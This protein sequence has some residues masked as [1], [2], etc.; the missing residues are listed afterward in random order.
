MS[1]AASGQNST[2]N[3][4]ATTLE[5]GPSKSEGRDTN[6]NRLFLGDNLEVMRHLAKESPESIDLVYIDPPFATG[7]AWHYNPEPKTL[8]SSKSQGRKAIHA[9]AYDDDWGENIGDYIDWMKDR[10]QLIHKLLQPEG[11]LLLHCDHRANHHLS[12]LC[13]E[14]FGPGDRR[15]GP[16][17]AGFR[18]EIIWSYGLGGSSPRCYPKKH[19]TI[20]WYTKSE[21]WTFKPPM[22]PAT[23]AK[24]KGKLK[25]A[26]DTWQIP[27]L[28]NMARE[29]TGYPTQKP[30]ALLERIIEAHTNP[31]DLV[32]DFFC[33]SGTT[34]IAAERGK[35]RWLGCD[36]TAMSIH[37]IKK[38]L[39][40]LQNPK[41][42]QIL[43][44]NASSAGKGSLPDEKLKAR[45]LESY[46]SIPCAPEEVF[47]ARKDNT[48]IWIAPSFHPVRAEDLNQLD[49]LAAKNPQENIHILGWKWELNDALICPTL[50]KDFT[51]IQLPRTL[52]R[53]Q[54]RPGSSHLFLE[55]PRIEIDVESEGPGSLTVSLKKFWYAH[56]ESLPV[57]IQAT[58]KGSF[59]LLDLWGLDSSPTESPF[60]YL[61]SSS[62]NRAVREIQTRTQISA[63]KNQRGLSLRIR[64]ADVFGTNIEIKVPLPSTP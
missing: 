24:L 27:T 51:L 18:N 28:N 58:E 15:P 30:L 8:D 2:R 52:L 63:D 46:E 49:T 35:R 20:L 56:P 13:D 54:A 22:V 11:S 62:R 37:V 43:G 29:R 19:D 6:D 40:E 60:T 55:R 25:K 5:R 7:L 38:R 61:W 1:T 12:I 33:G 45:I 50:K 53:S 9:K 14:I 4:F 23:S 42:F 64:A 10:L 31:G 26:P 44:T 47:H 59:D 16:T 34:V 36:E 32:A 57:E 39:L 3:E 48:L 41:P 21:Q 17:R